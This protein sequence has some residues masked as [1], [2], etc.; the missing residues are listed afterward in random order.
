MNKKAHKQKNKVS[1]T[2]MVVGIVLILLLAQMLIS[3]RLAIAGEEV[4]SLEIAAQEIGDENQ[5]LKERINQMG[6]LSRV[7]Q[8]SRM[9]GLVKTNQVLYLTPQVP[10]ALK[11]GQ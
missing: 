2:L 1:L 10:V 8:Q 4:K 11:T 5:L 3:Y 9:L 6:S 7:Q